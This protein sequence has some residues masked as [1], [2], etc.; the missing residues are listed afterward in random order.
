M[1]MTGERM[2]GEIEVAGGVVGYDKVGSGPALVAP[3]GA[4][5]DFFPT[6]AFFRE[7][8]SDD[9]TVITTDFR[10]TGRTQLPEKDYLFGDLADDT[11]AVIRG[12][13]FERAHVTGLSHTGQVAQQIA[14][15]HP[16]LVDHLVLANT[17]RCGPTRP[18][19][20]D[21]SQ[22]TAEDYRKMGITAETADLLIRGSTGESGTM[23]EYLRLAFAPRTLERNPTFIEDH[24]KALAQRR[25]PYETQ[26]RGPDA[27]KR[28]WKAQARTSTVGQLSN[29]RARTLVLHGA[30]DRVIDRNEIWELWQE[31]PGAL[32][33]ILDNV[34]HGYP[35][36]D[37]ERA[38]RLIKAFF[39]DEI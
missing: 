19:I 38:T 1:V 5:D 33:I 15:R 10:D 2:Q 21:V 11:A 34:G 30:D 23:E 28:F 31:I 7:Y 24:V 35:T 20:E 25:G 14:L 6:A 4:S 36:E 39:R 32:F 8:F 12:L 9:Y 22:M 13:G 17:S 26:N 16:D 37:P 29:I 3:G 27:A 18:D